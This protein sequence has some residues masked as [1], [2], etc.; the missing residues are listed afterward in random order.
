MESA[1]D[2][3]GRE[4]PPGERLLWSGRP[5]QGLRLRGADLYLIPI[6]LCWTAFAVFA[7]VSTLTREEPALG[8]AIN[9]PFLLLLVA[10]GVYM[11]VGRLWVDAY[12]RRGTCYG[13]TS[14]RVV[15]VT[16]WFRRVSVHSLVL[17]QIAEVRLT[18]F[19]HG[20][21]LIG[22]GSIPSWWHA[23]AGWPAHNSPGLVSLELAA[24]ARVVYQIIRD[25]QSLSAKNPVPKH[26]Q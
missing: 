8:A 26:P 17:Q 21:G 23:G 3:I 19:R 11:L 20:D 1:E 10:L 12:W 16:T 18:L 7:L 6:G 9:A 4:I 2:V 13:V 15:V 25:V 14:E 24:D 22:F 5:P